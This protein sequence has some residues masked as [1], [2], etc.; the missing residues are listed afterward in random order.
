MP[1]ALIKVQAELER[2]ERKER[3]LT[4]NESAERFNRRLQTPWQMDERMNSALSCAGAAECGQFYAKCN[5]MARN[6]HYNA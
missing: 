2:I 3:Q 5:K 4:G 6:G 1:S